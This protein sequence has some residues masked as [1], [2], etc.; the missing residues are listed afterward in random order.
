MLIVKTEK[1]DAKVRY[2]V[3]DYC[4]DQF[5][6]NPHDHQLR[7]MGTVEIHTIEGLRKYDVCTL[8]ARKIAA[9]FKVD[10]KQSDMWVSP[11]KPEEELTASNCL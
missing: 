8:C 5:K 1:I 11:K 3:C 10:G 9:T 7:D 2:V 6:A 4:G